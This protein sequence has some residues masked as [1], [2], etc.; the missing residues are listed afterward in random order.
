MVHQSIQRPRR[1]HLRSV[2]GKR[3]HHDPGHG[4]R[5]IVLWHGNQSGLYRRHCEAR[6]GIPEGAVPPGG[7]WRHV[8]RSCDR[9]PGRPQQSSM[10]QA[11][12]LAARLVAEDKLSNA[13]IGRKCGVTARCIEKWK[14]KP[15]FLAEVAS[16]KKAWK[17]QVLAEGLSDRAF[18]IKEAQADYDKLGQII[19]ERGKDPS[20][21][22]GPGG[23]TGLITRTLQSLNG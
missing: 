8:R 1:R 13:Q 15:E 7:R 11:K 19:V 3:H 5:P 12:I 20:M 10:T 22:G 21:K 6:A 9:A 2:P 18:R 14:R 4:P 23:K 16:H 17:E